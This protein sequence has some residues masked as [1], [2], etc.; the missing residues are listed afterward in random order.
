MT[1]FRILGNSTLIQLM[2]AKVTTFIRC[3]KVIDLFGNSSLS[4][5]LFLVL[6]VCSMFVWQT[7][8]I[9]RNNNG[10]KLC[11]RGVYCLAIKLCTWYSMKGENAVC[12]IEIV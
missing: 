8:I 7:Q 1:L 9:V 2:L 11:R 3:C 4:S 12:A 6:N 5:V 10:S